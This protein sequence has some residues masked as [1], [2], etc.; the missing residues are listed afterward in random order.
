MTTREVAMTHRVTSRSLARPPIEASSGDVWTRPEDGAVMVYVPP[1]PFVMGSEVGDDDERPQ[2]TVALDGFWVDRTPVTNAQFVAFLNEEGN[3][4]VGSVPWVDLQNPDGRISY[5]DE[6]FGFEEGYGDH[7]VVGVS[8]YGARDYAAW[9]GG[10]LPSE[11]EWEKAARGTDGQVYPWGDGP[12][13]TDLC[14][15]G[16][17]VGRTTPVGRYSPEGDS[18]YGCADMAGNVWEW[19][20]SLREDYPYDPEDGRETLDALGLRALRGGTFYGNAHEVRCAARCYRSPHGQKGVNGF[21]VG[22][23]DSTS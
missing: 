20:R 11:A 23:P 15:Y 1:G 21:R 12:P 10:R 5:S 6:A 19:T 3:Q 14:N 13:T 18:P 22:M 7:P 16:Y 17:N 2:H 4:A 9:V 8:W